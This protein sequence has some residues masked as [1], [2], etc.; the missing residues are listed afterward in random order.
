MSGTEQNREMYDRFGVHYHQKRLALAGG[1]WNRWVD[2]P[3]IESMLSGLESPSRTLDL[4]CGSGLLTRWLKEQGFDVRGLDFSETLIEIARKELPDIE[5]HLG[6]AKR[7]SLDAQSLDLV[8]SGL[9]MHYEPDLNPLFREVARI[10]EAGGRFVFTMHHPVMEVLN[11]NSDDLAAATMRPYFHSEPYRWMMLDDEMELVSYHH[12]FE[13][14]SAALESN[15]FVIEQI[16]EGRMPPE[17]AVEFPKDFAR[18]NA[19]PSFVGFRTRL[20]E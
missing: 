8:V 3:M 11:V 13:S 18:T 6:D 14:I 16:K 17:V 20:T 4:G 10:L 19:F 12:T 7:T 2:K 15:G 9:V 1:A 5:F